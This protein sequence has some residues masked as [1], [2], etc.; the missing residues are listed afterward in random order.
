MS[1]GLRSARPRPR[2]P[3]R[4]ALAAAALVVLVVLASVGL[5][6]VR[7]KEAPARGGVL[8]EGVVIDLSA[9]GGSGFSLLPAFADAPPSRD[10]AGLLYRGLTRTGP[11]G[12]PQ[13]EL[14][15]KWEVDGGVKVFTFHLRRSLKWSDGVPLTSADAVYTLGV[16]QDTSLAQTQ[17]GKTWGGITVAAPD[18]LTVVYTLPAPSAGFVNLTRIGLLP[19]HTLKPRPVAGLR[20]TTDAPTSG[21]FRIDHVERDRV[22]LRR[23]LHAFEPPWLDGIDLKLFTNSTAA[24][25]ALLAGDIDISAGLM[26]SDAA[27]VSSS[28]NRRVLRPGSFAYTEL[29][30][31]QKQP[32]LAD[33][34]VRRAIYQ[35][36]DR[37]RAIANSLQGY[38]RLDG[39]PI[40]PSIGWAAAPDLGIA[41]NRTAAAKALDGAG[42]KQL[43]KGAVRVNKD[44]A[45]LELKLAAVDLDPYRMVATQAVADLRAV[46]V[47]TKLNLLSGQQLLAELQGRN[48]DMVLTALDNGPDP[49]IYV[50]WHS[51]QAVTGGFNFSGMPRDAFLDKDLE[52]GRFTY[53]LKTRKAA[54]LDA[55]RILRQ[56]VAAGFLFTPDVLVGFNNRVKGVHVNPA[57]ESGG[58]Y[59]FVSDWYVESQR[60]SK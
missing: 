11:D 6:F 43:R 60:V 20:D 29:L 5:Y 33:V 54:Y 44:G 53:D 34:A 18:P 9:G 22:V 51:S 28:L 26:P 16:L 13:P 52:D 27:R 58:R 10:V 57:I 14:A 50:F 17:A 1:R 38:G 31:N 30:F 8:T 37:R 25:Q 3:P 47:R 55:Q 36:I 12:R 4:L 24:V 32:T 35:A 19:Q 56:D 59:D 15:A 48:F 21:P 2:V 46:G 40:P 42:W 45:P 7:T 41:T 39:S 23:N 49:D